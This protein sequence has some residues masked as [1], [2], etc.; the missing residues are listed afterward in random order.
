MWDNAQASTESG[1]AAAAASIQPEAQRARLE[2]AV[3]ERFRVHEL[4]G[5]GLFSSVYRATDL[6]TGSEVALKLLSVDLREFPRLLERLES[7]RVS[8][9]AIR[10][11]GLVS[12]TSIEQHESMSLLVMPFAERGSLADLLR[13]RG[14]LP[15]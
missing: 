4:V 6:R 15:L 8:C 7:S 9:T 1:P 3:A 14:P 11:V 13:V 12:P 10:M 5:T 2:A